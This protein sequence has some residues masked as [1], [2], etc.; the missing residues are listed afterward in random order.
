MGET[1]S[2]TIDGREVLAPKG[3]TVYDAAAS[4]GIA[5]PALCRSE[6]APAMSACRLCL[7]EVE[8]ARALAAS[9]SLPVSARMVVRTGTERVRKARRMNLELILSD[10]DVVCITCERSGS[11]ALERYAYE[12]G[13]TESR[14]TGP[15]RAR[16]RR[17]VDE[18]N[19][20]FVRDYNKCILCGLCVHACADL[21][22][23]SAIDYAGRGFGT[24][25]ATAFDRP[26]AETTCEF[27][28]RCISVC[29]VGALTERERVRKGREWE[30]SVTSTICPYCGCGCTVDLHLREGRLVKVGSHARDTANRGNL[31][32]KGKFGLQF[33]DHPER[34]RTPLI[35][36]D[37]ELVPASWDEALDLVAR[38]LKEIRDRDGPDA[39]GGLASAKCTNE[40]N[41]VFQRFIR[42]AIGTNNVDH[43]A[44]LCHASTVAGLAR[45][46]GSG[47]MT[48]PIGDL[49]DAACI[50]VTGSNTTEAHPIVGIEIKAAVL[51][52]GAALIV[53]DPREIDLVQ[54]AR[55]WLRHRSGTD[56]A[57]F[58]GMMHVILAEGLEDRAFIEARTEGFDA[59]RAVAMAYTPERAASITGVPAE[60]IIEAA[61]LYAR[62]RASAIVYSM[63]ITQHTTGTNNVMTLANL[64]MLTGHVG[65]PSTGVN[66][67][68]GQNNVQG[69]CD[70]GCLPNVFPG[71]QPVGRAEAWAKFERAWGTPLSPEPGLTVVE[72]LHRAGEGKVR[73]LYIMGENPFLSD[74]NANRVRLDLESLEFLVV[75][76]IFLSETARMAHVVLPAASFAEK[77]GTFTNTERKVQL[78]RQVRRPPGEAR[79]D[80]RIICDVSGRMGYPIGYASS[81][82]IMDEIARLTPIYGGIRHGRLEPRGLAWPCPDGGH[83]GTP[84]LHVS[85]FTRGKG[86]FSPIE[87]IPPAE[88]PDRDYPLLLTTGRILYHFHTGTMTRRVEGLDQIRPEGLVEINPE[89]GRALGLADGDL[90]EVTS[91]RGSVTARCSLTPRSRPGSVFLAFHFAEAAANLLTNDALDPVAKIPELK[92]CA[93]R[94]RP[95]A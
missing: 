22:M 37:G 10:H 89:D 48:N 58:N 77:D 2:L 84:I 28:G 62:S 88:E 83:P 5:I 31:C 75:Q 66:P 80:W 40:E 16:N 71:Y 6:D 65:K 46:F 1:V 36:R 86:A 63:G 59:F 17:P 79:S 95:C 53:A 38:R 82:E 18:A 51:K 29:P 25:I 52:N 3:S 7:V 19:P 74:P 56:V 54:Y 49:R 69:A 34:L 70:M 12:F 33:I 50:L 55:L 39:I 14:F 78:L 73:G 23:D 26:I 72:M 43:C 93:V 24:R 9:C 15:E 41:Y 8:G 64:A 21:Q 92:V 68:R 90:V 94:V 67:L 76:D 20:F 91:R 45:S 30:L 81:A 44:R 35:R 27:C 85:Q 4:L 87:Y 61:R 11:C 47:A 13:I 57:L 42:A 32:V 60:K